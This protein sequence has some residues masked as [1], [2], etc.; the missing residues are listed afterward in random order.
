M[1]EV[2]Q[3]PFTNQ[4]LKPLLLG[5]QKKKKRLGK[6]IEEASL[7]PNKSPAKL[8]APLLDRLMRIWVMLSQVWLRRAFSCVCGNTRANV[9]SAFVDS[10]SHA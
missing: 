4:T 9:C 8:T 5:A 6:S 1:V 10:K 3:Q 7:D 2:Q